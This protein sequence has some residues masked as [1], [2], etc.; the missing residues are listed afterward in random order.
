MVVVSICS[1]WNSDEMTIEKTHPILQSSHSYIA[2][3]DKR[4][5][6]PAQQMFSMSTTNGTR[7]CNLGLPPWKGQSGLNWK[8]RPD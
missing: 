7:V 5:C 1:M 8:N 4:V 6:I 3:D 2:I